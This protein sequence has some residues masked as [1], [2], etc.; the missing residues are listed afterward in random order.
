MPPRTKITKDMIINAAFEIIRDD[1]DDMINARKIAE[2]LKCSTQPVLYQFKSME[3]IKNAVYEK[4]DD[5]HTSYIMDIKGIVPNP[6]LEIG[7][8]YI[9]FAYE[10]KEL[11]KYLFQTDKFSS[12]SLVDLVDDERLSPIFQMISSKIGI[13]IKGAKEV[14]TAVFLTVHG[15]AAMIANNSMKY[16]EEHTVKLLQMTFC[17]IVNEIKRGE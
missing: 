14:F 1:G 8:L 11:F 10:E 13:D 7:I 6:I 12:K 4:I 5:Y 9:R 3:E 17:G 2:K 15:M 16:D